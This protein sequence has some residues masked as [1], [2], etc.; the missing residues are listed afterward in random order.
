MDFS[1]PKPIKPLEKML[2]IPANN[3]AT[4]VF[5]L[6]SE[7][8]GSGLLF[9]TE[10]DTLACAF[11]SDYSNYSDGLRK[12][13]HHEATTYYR[14]TDHEL[15]EILSTRISVVM[16]GTNG[17]VATL[18]PSAENGL[19]SRYM[20]YH[21]NIQLVWKNVFAKSNRGLEAYFDSLG[22]EFLP[23]YNVP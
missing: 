12:A 7:N 1:M 10:G 8:E 17:Q 5:Q 15:V 23:L 11:K 19:F 13:F 4:G 18:I 6:L 22:Q 20:F 21:M 3:S 9:E 16:S 2:I 14:R